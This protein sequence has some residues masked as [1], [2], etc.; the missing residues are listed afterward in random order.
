VLLG[1]SL[2]DK[3][4][5]L[6]RQQMID[7]F[8]LERVTKAPASFDSKKLW[9]FQDHYQQQLPLAEKVA[10]MIPYLVKAELLPAEVTSGQRQLLERIVTAAGD[11][12][13]VAGDILAYADFFFRDDFAYDPVA[14]EKHLRPAPAAPRLL[15]FRQRLAGLAEFDTAHLEACLHAFLTDEGLKVG[16]MIHAIRVAVTG[17]PVG[18][19]LYDC[20]EILGQARALARLD[21]ALARVES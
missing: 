19:G 20:L 2:D 21:R 7:N 14:F 12:L 18:P 16:D 9:A 4:E 3:T 1:W 8:S 5:F 11:R 17:K 6:S 15:R 10:G 13:K